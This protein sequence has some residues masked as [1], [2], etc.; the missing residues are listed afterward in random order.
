MLFAKANEIGV[1]AIKEVLAK[2]CDESGQLIS[3]EKS[4]VYFSPNIHEGVKDRIYAS[5]G[6]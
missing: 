5:L 2:F 4:R 6:I 3:I 1:E